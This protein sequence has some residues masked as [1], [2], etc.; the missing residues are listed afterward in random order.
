LTEALEL[1]ERVGH[2]LARSLILDSIS[3]AHRC[4]GDYGSAME[5]V[6]EAHAYAMGQGILEWEAWTAATV[7]WLLIELRRPLRA[8]SYLE[9]GLVAAER[10]AAASQLARCSSFLVLAL[11][12]TGDTGAAEKAIAPAGQRLGLAHAGRGQ[13]WLFGGHCYVALAD[14]HREL[15]RPAEGRALIDPLL[16]IAERSGWCE[17]IARFS[18][19]TAEC[20]LAAGDTRAAQAGFERGL[21]VAAESG[22][23]EPRALAHAGLAA[24]G[25]EGDDNM[26]AARRLFLELAKTLEEPDLKQGL[27]GAAASGARSGRT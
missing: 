20:A 11:A 18:I 5:S 23:P 4:R 14:A 15:G 6:R 16:P 1:S 12:R 19:T 17:M 27:L 10:S 25:V 9:R 8:I 2:G 21:G 22:M 3:S 13:A 7:G 24:C 26:A